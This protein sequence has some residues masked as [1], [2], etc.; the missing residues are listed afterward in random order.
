MTTIRN[1]RM[2]IMACG[3][4]LLRARLDISDIAT[5]TLKENS[6]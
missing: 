4:V 5:K 2:A 1:E 3:G 6:A